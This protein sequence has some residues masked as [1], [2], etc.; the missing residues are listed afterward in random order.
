MITPSYAITATER[1]L[2]RLALD[3]TTASL[4]SRV[5]FT[6][7]T[8]ASNP[9]TYTNSNG[10]IT[11][12]TNN[13]PRFDYDP[14][15]LVCK[16]LLIEESRTNLALGSDAFNGSNWT[17]TRC[18]VD[19]DV[20]L[21]PDNTTNADKFIEDTSSGTHALSTTGLLTISSV[22]YTGSVYAKAGERSWVVVGIGASVAGLAYFNLSN[23]TVGTVTSGFTASITSAGNGW[24]RCAISGTIS[25]SNQSAM[26]IY[27]ATGNGGVSYVGNGT[28]G[29]FVWGAQ[30][31][32]GAFAT[33]YIPTTTTAL[34]RN[35]DVATMTGTNFSDWYNSS[36]GA[37]S[38]N[39]QTYVPALQSAN[40][41]AVQGPAGANMTVYSDGGTWRFRT[42]L[43]NMNLNN[44]ISQNGLNDHV[45]TYAT[46]DYKFAG[47]GTPIQ[48][49]TGVGAISG[50]DTLY[51]GAGTNYGAAKPINGW[52]SKISFWPQR[53][54]NNEV[55]AFSKL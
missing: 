15:T 42:N 52:V 3:F 41:L 10:Y 46:S 26:S 49:N 36:Q 51:V 8:S 31:E 11:A 17:R 25:T 44:G 54:T 22:A 20:T 23:G 30:L 33:S 37:F 9:A 34:T 5:T 32:T 1:V 21:S 39:F 40:I 14:I 28:N 35:A 24:Y 19:P 48:T 16:G 50:L 53:I 4:D 12:A 2:P 29:A 7:A 43:A 27:L 18:S 47:N 6:R 13:Q 38:V 45:F 55:V